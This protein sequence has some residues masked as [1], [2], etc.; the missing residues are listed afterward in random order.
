MKADIAERVDD[1]LE[2]LF[3]GDDPA[4]QAA[5]AASAAA[6][7]P[8]IAVSPTQGKLLQLFARMLGAQ[9]MLEVG[10]L[11]GYSAICLAR[12][13]PPNGRLITLELDRTHA[14]VAKQ[15]L[16]RAG[17]A[18]LVDV[19]VGPALDSLHRMIAQGTQPFDLIF[20]DADK[21]NSG[22]YVR[23]ALALSHP[24]TVIVLDNV[25]RDGHVI[26]ASSGD[27]AIVGTREALAVMASDPRLQATAIQTVGH[28]GYDGFAIAIVVK[29]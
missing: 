29:G 18:S 22:N 4:L 17:L 7:L 6:G 20:I 28:K 10:T 13:L 27:G 9:R 2:S 24:G 1:Y 25:I 11:G 21:A 5:L 14:D 23:L 19:V 8:P 12:A 15:N 16:E 3:G 26:D